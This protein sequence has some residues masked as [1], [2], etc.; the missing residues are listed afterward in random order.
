[1]SDEKSA[2]EVMRDNAIF[3]LKQEIRHW[4]T[5]ASVALAE[6][7]RLSTAAALQ[8]AENTTAETI[9]VD[10][11]H[12]VYLPKGTLHKIAG[13][14]DCLDIETHRDIASRAGDLAPAHVVR[15]DDYFGATTPN[16]DLCIVSPKAEATHL[17][18]MTVDGKPTLAGVA[19]GPEMTPIFPERPVYA[20]ALVA[21]RML[22]LR[23]PEAYGKLLA[24]VQELSA[25]RDKIVE[26]E[27]EQD[28]PGKD[29][30]K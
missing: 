27:E 14:I 10:L 22:R 16:D 26:R 6:V 4:R 3:E 15:M 9:P 8:V 1:M 2:A 23:E 25:E 20:H 18:P 24:I 21:L 12:C 5:V 13:E 7:S 17:C 29:G 28:D 19:A 30:G 11:P